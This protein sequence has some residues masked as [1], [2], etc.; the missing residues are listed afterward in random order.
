VRTIKG[1]DKYEGNFCIGRMHGKGVMTT[2]GGDRRVGYWN[3]GEE[4]GEMGDAE[5][6]SVIAAGMAALNPTPYTVSPRP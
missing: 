4:L 5:A 6:K 2:S 1:Q 3:M